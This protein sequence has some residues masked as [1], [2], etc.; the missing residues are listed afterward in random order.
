MNCFKHPEVAAVTACQECNL[1]MCADCVKNKQNMA[2]NRTLCNSCAFKNISSFVE[3]VK[4]EIAGIDKRF[5]VTTGVLVVGLVL[6]LIG[7]FGAHGLENAIATML[8]CF[9]IGSYTMTPKDEKS[10]EQ[11]SLDRLNMTMW[12]QSQH[13]G[14]FMVGGILGW[15]IRLVLFPFAYV[16]FFFNYKKTKTQ[17]ANVIAEQEKLLENLKAA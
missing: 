11:K 1:G 4:A 6:S 8:I 5:K 3:A 14:A 17:A 15:V 13:A 7:F 9:G 12:L 16:I 2:D 10:A